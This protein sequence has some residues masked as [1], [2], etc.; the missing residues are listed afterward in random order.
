MTIQLRDSDERR[1]LVREVPLSEITAEERGGEPHEIT[2]IAGPREGE[3]HH[4]IP[5]P[6]RLLR[7]RTP[8]GADE[9]LQAES[10]GC[11]HTTLRL[12]RGG[13]SGDRGRGPEFV[14]RRQRCRVN[15]AAETTEG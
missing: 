6:E 7:R 4:R 12:S 13:S 2:I 15:A 10:A 1:E 14:K 5:G 11:L 3:I 9:S 8:G